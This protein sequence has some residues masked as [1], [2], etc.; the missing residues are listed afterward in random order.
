MRNYNNIGIIIPALN[1]DCKMLKML[2]ELNNLGFNNMVCV[3]DGSEPVYDSVFE[4]A[5]DK[6]NC[7]ILKHATNLGKGR[8]LK[9]AFNYV[10]N[11]NLL[12]G[13]CSYCRCRWTT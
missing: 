10:L 3:N 9:T 5:K 8:A 2:E 11:Q 13:G 7:I 12:L 4:E 1:P 6:Y